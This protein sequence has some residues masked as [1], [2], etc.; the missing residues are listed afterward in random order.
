MIERKLDFF[1]GPVTPQAHEVS[2]EVMGPGKKTPEQLI[3]PGSAPYKQT[4]EEFQRAVDF[5]AGRPVRN[6][7]TK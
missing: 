7:E 6:R 3:G 4:E 1:V 5:F 2:K